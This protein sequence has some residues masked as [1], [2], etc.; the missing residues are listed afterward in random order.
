MELPK[1]LRINCID[2]LEH[3][4]LR[5]PSGNIL[6]IFG[7]HLTVWKAI[8]CDYG[9]NGCRQ[10]I[11]VQRHLLIVLVDVSTVV[12]G[13]VEACA[14]RLFELI[15]TLTDRAKVVQR[16]THFGCGF[17]RAQQV[18]NC[19]RPTCNTPAVGTAD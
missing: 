10:P 19:F 15:V 17:V 18:L 3:G 9:T 6:K 4:Q 8:T 16:V 7:G 5:L 2:V 14:M 1:Y 11:D 12:N 13:I